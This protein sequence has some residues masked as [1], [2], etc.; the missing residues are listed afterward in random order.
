MNTIIR[1]IVTV[2]FV[3]LNAFAAALCY[4][5]GVGVMAFDAFNQTAS[6][7]LNIKVGDV[8]L[9]MNIVFL[10]GQIILLRRDFKIRQLLQIPVS[11]I[12]SG[13]INF[14]LYDLYKFE[15]NSYPINLLIFLLGVVIMAFAIAVVMEM[16]F[17]TFPLEGFWMAFSRVTGKDFAKSRQAF[18]VILIVVSLGLSLIYNKP[19]AI[20]EGT[21]IGA[22]LFS[23]T[24]GFFMEKLSPILKRLDLKD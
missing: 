5:A 23:P 17:V 19:L 14:A 3:T 10:L 16:D 2:F 7:V 13:G 18:D 20:R 21:I 6:N 8:V 12:L 22:L 11:F 1:G 15:V 4:K 24:M 9:V